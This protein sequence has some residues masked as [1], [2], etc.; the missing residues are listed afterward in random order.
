MICSQRPLLREFTDRHQLQQE[1]MDMA[2]ALP[3]NSP[4][5]NK[6]QATT[7]STLFN[8]LEHPPKSYLGEQHQYRTAD[9]SHHVSSYAQRL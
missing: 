7:V 2:G 5:R 4:F 3:F 8:S 1:L 6:V 9:G